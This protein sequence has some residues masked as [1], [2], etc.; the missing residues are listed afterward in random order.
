MKSLATMVSGIRSDQRWS[1]PTVISPEQYQD[2]FMNGIAGLWRASPTRPMEFER[3]KTPPVA[4]TPEVSPIK[5]DE[6]SCDDY[7]GV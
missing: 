7:W 4:V 5:H 1:K 6:C 3:Q 2:R